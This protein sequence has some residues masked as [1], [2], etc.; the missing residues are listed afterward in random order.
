VI[1][2]ATILATIAMLG[3]PTGVQR[4]VGKAIAEKNTIEIAKYIWSSLLLL[5][6]GII[7][8]SVS[9][10]IISQ[11]LIAIFDIDLG[12]ILIALALVA[13]MALSTVFRAI[14][15]ST[16]KTQI[17]PIV[18]VLST[19]VKVL[20]AIVLALVGLGAVG[21]M[22]GF[23]SYSIISAIV[24]GAVCLRVVKHQ[25]FER[26]H[27]QWRFHLKEIT[28]A[29]VVVW[30]PTIIYT[31]G[32][33]LGP[34]AVFGING[35]SGAG[36]F[37]MA[38]A[39][40]IAISAVMQVLFNIALPLLSGMT[41]GRKRLIWKTIK[42][43][44]VISV[45]L[46]FSLVFYSNDIMG[47]LG[48]EYREGSLPLSILLLSIIPILLTTGI[49]T[50]ALA[51]RSYQDVLAIGLAANVPRA[52]LYLLLLPA[53]GNTGAALAYTL[54]SFVGLIISLIIAA[55][56]GM[57]LDLKF[58]GSTTLIP[59]FLG[60][61]LSYVQIN[62]LLGIVLTIIVS[63]VL[64]LKLRIYTIAEITEVLEFLPVSV[65]IKISRM[66]RFAGKYL[67]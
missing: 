42:L 50:L 39:V 38:L 61:T 5:T 36:I 17:L 12:L 23:A 40:T 13:S 47:L 60:L 63:Y 53:Y 19:V 28:S 30:V 25:M 14:V 4:F 29:S 27:M 57:G 43:S 35:A 21:V 44:A 7:A 52:L 16:L 22:M 49:T 41:D 34:I 37:F 3:I 24:L 2:L 11:W 15:I 20:L 9:V 6:L 1:S 51:Y 48:D 62:Y 32:I 33:H 65:S 54:G 64:I 8:S 10:L 59:L 55:R 26:R 67:G 45:P 66:I 46:S 56:R 58:L 31:V 18:L